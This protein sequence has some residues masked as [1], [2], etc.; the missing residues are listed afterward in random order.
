MKLE[1]DPRRCLV[2]LLLLLGALVLG[3][4]AASASGAS[5]SP[6]A[7]RRRSHDRRRR[8]LV[9]RGTPTGGG[10]YPFLAV[11]DW[12]DHKH[13][14]LDPRVREIH[15]NAF[16]DSAVSALITRSLPDAGVYC[17]ELQVYLVQ[18]S[19]GGAGYI[20]DDALLST[21]YVPYSASCRCASA[22]P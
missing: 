13:G 22:R 7:L 5:S 10:K 4:V 6:S 11:V 15:V 1:P 17:L 21:L 8:R 16:R 18:R 14:V 12:T 20:V 19:D 9:T 2:L 3:H